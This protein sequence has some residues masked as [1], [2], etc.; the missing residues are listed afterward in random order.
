M[1][2]LTIAG[3]VL[4]ALGVILNQVSLRSRT[5]EAGEC[6]PQVIWAAR[7]LFTWAGWRLRWIGFLAALGG[8]ALLIASTL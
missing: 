8:V 1:D 6:D 7:R 3:L 4:V 5:E 2:W